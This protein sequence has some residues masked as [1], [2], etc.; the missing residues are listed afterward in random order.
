MAPNLPMLMTE[1]SNKIIQTHKIYFH[2]TYFNFKGYV[3]KCNKNN[4]VYTQHKVLHHLI[5]CLMTT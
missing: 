2:L 1:T 5:E 4:N 3:P